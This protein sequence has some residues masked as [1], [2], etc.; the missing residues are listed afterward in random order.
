MGPNDFY[1]DD[2]NIADMEEKEEIPKDIEA[3]IEDWKNAKLVGQPV[4]NSFI[5]DYFVFLYLHFH[6]SFLLSYFT[7]IFNTKHYTY[8]YIY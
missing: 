3:L 6:I 7:L 5:R 8:F 4:S 2:W 1:N